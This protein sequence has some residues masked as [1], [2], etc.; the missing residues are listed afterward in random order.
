MKILMVRHG[1][2]DYN[3]NHLVQGSTNIPL[4]QEGINQAIK[5]SEKIRDYKIARAYSSPLDRAYDTCRYMLDNSNN[6]DIEITKDIRVIE[7]NYGKFEGA[8]YEEWR[9]GRENN[10]LSSVELDT[11]VAK[12]VEEF[13]KEKYVLHENE[14]ILVVCHGACTRIFLESKNLRPNKNYIINTSLNELEYNGSE[15]KLLKYNV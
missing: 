1:E 3:K 7:K 15:F 2:T 8:T 10:D 13:L 9:K 11:N 4:N 5:A 14:T 12:R 6:A